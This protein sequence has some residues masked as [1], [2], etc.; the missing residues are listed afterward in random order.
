M[1]LLV[2]RGPSQ[3]IAWEFAELL[4]K[5]I[6]ESLEGEGSGVRGQDSEK[7]DRDTATG[8][9]S[10]EYGV[11]EGA[12]VPLAVPVSESASVP[13]AM[14][15]LKSA[16]VPLAMP[17]LKSARVL[18][19]A[20]APFARLRGLYRFQ[21]QLQGLEGDKLRS[22][23]RRA[24]AEVKPPDGVQWIADVDPIDMM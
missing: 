4:G 21:I 16:S 3:P 17:V 2:I 23:V 24:T 11:R 14:P 22:A 19:P 12:S 5:R 7:D 20:P 9:G 15:V 13:L 8:V 10:T 18:G 6:K 1:I